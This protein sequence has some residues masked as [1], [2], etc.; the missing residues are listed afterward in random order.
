MR[1]PAASNIIRLL[2]S[3]LALA[4]AALTPACRAP[5]PSDGFCG[6]QLRKGTLTALQHPDGSLLLS[7]QR[8]GRNVYASATL[9]DS[10]RE[11]FAVLET[12][13]S[14]RNAW[15]HAKKNTATPIRV[16]GTDAWQRI[17]QQL[18]DRIAPDRPR[19]GIMVTILVESTISLNCRKR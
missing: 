16:F 5:R 4:A 17:K 2:A 9:P 19:T 11:Q 18:A 14:A 1:I 15:H 10:P 3:G 13:T 12:G 6:I 7:L 8:S